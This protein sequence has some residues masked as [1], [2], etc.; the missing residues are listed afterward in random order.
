MPK[1]TK[2]VRNKK[3]KKNDSTI[4]T[5]SVS[6]CEENGKWIQTP[7]AYLE[8]VSRLALNLLIEQI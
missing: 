4:Y 1:R 5:I 8:N 2:M 7:V 6:F 3:V